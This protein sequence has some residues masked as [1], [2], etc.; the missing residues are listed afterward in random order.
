MIENING[1]NYILL[2]KITNNQFEIGY[3]DIVQNQLSNENKVMTNNFLFEE[4]NVHDSLSSLNFQQ[5][6]NEIIICIY[7]PREAKFRSKIKNEEC[8][9]ESYIKFPFDFAKEKQK[10]FNSLIKSFCESLIFLDNYPRCQLNV[11]LNVLRMESEIS[12]KVAIYNGIM[13]ALNLS[14]LDLKVFA[15]TTKY[16]CNNNNIL[17]T[18]DAINTENIL[19][20][21]SDEPLSIQNYE[22]IISNSSEEIKEFY[23][24]FKKLLV[25]KLSN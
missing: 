24:K 4:L 17:I 22:N 19:F 11:V 3:S 13:L 15:L 20:F 16:T 9:I 2:D 1:N 23:I 14:G 21:D 10:Y 6:N 12:L 25:K 5:M 18:F 8:F 7:G